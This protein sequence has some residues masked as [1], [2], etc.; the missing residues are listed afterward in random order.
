MPNVGFGQTGGTGGCSMRHLLAG[1]ARCLNSER[2]PAAELWGIVVTA[3][4]PEEP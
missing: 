1:A 4:C 2:Q 3:A